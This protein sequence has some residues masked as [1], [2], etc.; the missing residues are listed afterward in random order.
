[1]GRV[2]VLERVSRD[3]LG[4]QCLMVLTVLFSLSGKEEGMKPAES[5]VSREVSL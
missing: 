4:W 2:E 1:M 3:G 5:E